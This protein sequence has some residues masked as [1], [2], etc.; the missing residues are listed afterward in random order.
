MELNLGFGEFYY[1]V[2]SDIV[3][4]LVESNFDEN[5]DEED[6]YESID[7]QRIYKEYCKYYVKYLFD[8]ILDTDGIKLTTKS[9]NIDMWSPREYNFSTDVIILKDVPKST[10][11]KLTTLFN[12]YLEGSKFRDFIKVKTT[13]RDGYMPLYK[14]EDVVDKKDLDVSLEFLLEFVANEFNEEGHEL[15]DKMSESLDIYFLSTNTSKSRE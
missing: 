6:Y 14:Y 1:S 4:F 3:D 8:Y 13:S 5:N 2:H 15:Y 7:Y 11:K 10:V 9:N 12:R